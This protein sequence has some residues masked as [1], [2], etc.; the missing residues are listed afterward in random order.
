MNQV[1]T[2]ISS[3]GNELMLLFPSPVFIY[4]WPNSELL[5]EDLKQVI[6]D[7]MKHSPG[8]VKTNRGGWQSESNL[9]TWKHECVARF[10]DN[11]NAAM[12]EF[13]RQL[14]PEADERHINGWKVHSCWANVNHKGAYNT[15]H[16][17]DGP[18]SLFSGFYYVDVGELALK[19]PPAPESPDV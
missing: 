3:T 5:N 18:Y 2:Q 8:T 4:R 19:R 10:L 1:N 9:H 6:L 15:S 17:H 16:H 11:L 12:G 14:V 7:N 13:I